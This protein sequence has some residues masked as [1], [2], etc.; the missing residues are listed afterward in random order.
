VNS[1]YDL[2]V[3]VGQALRA[4]G[5]TLAIAESCTG[6]GV[7]EAIT[8]VPGSSGW[9]D[10]G[11]ITYSNR[12]KHEMLGVRAATLKRFG[13]VS[14]E[15]VKEMVAGVLRESQADVALA[16]SGI[17]GPAGGSREKPVGT[18]CIGWELRRRF[19]CRKTFLYQGD[20]AAIRRQAIEDA[21]KGVMEI[22]AQASAVG[23]PPGAP[24]N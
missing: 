14:E 10:R 11:F 20:R 18:V 21:L 17:A 8:R 15:T 4:R 6:G 19:A 2:A 5:L 22:V 13:A 3:L 9:F 23:A 7:G 12:A 1:L 16:V 24:A